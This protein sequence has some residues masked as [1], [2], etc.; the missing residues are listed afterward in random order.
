MIINILLLTY[1][2]LLK[3]LKRK[4]KTAKLKHGQTNKNNERQQT[5]KITKTKKDVP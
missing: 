4:L 2:F 1:Y 5:K 3:Q